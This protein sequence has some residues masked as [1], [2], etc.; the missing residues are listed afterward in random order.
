MTNIGG[1][2]NLI[3][4]FSWNQQLFGNTH[5]TLCTNYVVPDTEQYQNNFDRKQSNTILMVHCMLMDFN[6]IY[7][8]LLDHMI[9]I[10]TNKYLMEEKYNK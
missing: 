7:N 4:Y 5:K 10:T 9:T 2:L 6:L 3:S 1:Q 8:N